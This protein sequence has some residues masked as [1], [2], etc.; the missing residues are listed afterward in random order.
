MP[1]ERIE[2]GDDQ[3]LSPA[4]PAGKKDKKTKD[5]ARMGTERIGKLLFEFS[6]P[7]VVMML[8]NSLYNVIDTAVLG[9]A[10][11]PEGVAVTT[12][13]LPIMQ[14]LMGFSMWAG[15]G[16][17][18]LAAIQMGAGERDKVEKTLGNTTFLLFALAAAMAVVAIVFI[19]PV[20]SIIG[21]TPTLWEQ[22]KIFVQIICFGTVFQ[23]LTGGLNAFLRTAGKPNLS[24]GMSLLGTVACIV[25]NVLFVV[26]LGFGVAGSALATILGQACGGIPVIVYFIFAKSSP[27]HLYAANLKPQG[28]VVRKILSLG[29]ASFIIQTASTLVSVVLNQVVNVWGATDPIGVDNGLAAIGVAQKGAVF[30]LMPILGVTMGAQPIVGFNYGARSWD[31]VIKTLKWSIITCTVMGAIYWLAARLFAVPIV[32][33]L[34]ITDPQLEAFA[35][36]ALMLY[37]LFYP[38][39]GAQIMAGSYFQSSGQPL[40]ASI[41]ELVRQVIF[42]MPLYLFMPG[43]LQGAFGVGSLMS[44]VW[45]APISDIMAVCVTTVFTVMEVVKLVGLRR[46]ALQEQAQ[47]QVQS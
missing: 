30:G 1:E 46:N 36:E 21:T 22:T 2:A 38:L 17:S 37:A 34:G 47:A 3:S 19:D 18:A 20:L 8:V 13:A 43:V 29:L 10:V 26:I 40:K 35:S 11:G 45:C 12:L 32:N 28:A 31:R 39:V 4:P 5:P 33:I 27:F 24:L 15:Q 42:L 16:G 14:L 41:L 6:L 23:S 9:Y 7:A 44:V 25:L